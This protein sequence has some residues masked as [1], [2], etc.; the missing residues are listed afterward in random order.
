[1]IGKLTGVVDSVNVNN[2]I[3]DVNGV[4]YLVWCSQDT[5]QTNKPGEKL[6]LFT[7]MAVRETALDL[8][9]FVEVND[10]SFFE[11]LLNVP[12]IGPRSA[13]AVLNIA[14]VDMMA[15][16]ISMGDSSYLTKVS[17]IGK[18]SAE[19]IVL[20]LRDKVAHLLGKNAGTEAEQ[21]T[22]SIARKDDID[23]L[24]AL[25]TLGYSQT[26]ARDALKELP[27]TLTGVQDRLR[28]ALKILSN[29]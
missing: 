24:E 22:S 15:D 14:P 17:G 29:R 1:M 27:E 10:L 8:Y 9:G 23:T 21:S 11:L 4:G 7:Y 28:A 2:L 12:G 5:L 13:L 20:E 26:Q 3:L 6:S 19:K 25:K 18:K 16:A